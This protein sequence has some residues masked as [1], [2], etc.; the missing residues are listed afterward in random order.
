MIHHEFDPRVTITTDDDGTNPR[1]T[2]VDLE[3]CYMDSIPDG[4]YIVGMD[5]GI[6]AATNWLADR[7]DRLTAAIRAVCTDPAVWTSSTGSNV[8][9]DDDEGVRVAV[10]PNTVSIEINGEP[11]V[12]VL[13]GETDDDPTLVIWTGE[14]GQGDS[15]AVHL[16]RINLNGDASDVL[17]AVI[18]DISL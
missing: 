1:L 11:R 16:G 10:V 13:F 14:E 5:K 4:N 8:F 17:E 18:A 12:G 2:K 3:G 6:A 7:A 15:V 9:V